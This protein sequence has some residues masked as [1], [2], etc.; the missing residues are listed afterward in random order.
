MIAKKVL[1]VGNFGVGKTSLIR[2]FVLNEF[3]EDYISTIGVRV[4][5]KIVE[6]N[7]EK[8]KLLIWDVAGTKDDEKVPKA[9]FLGAS[10]AMY[11]FDLSRE[12]TYLNIKSQINTVKELSGLEYITVVGNKKDLLT[13]TELEK[14]NKIISIPIDLVTSAKDDENVEDAFI[15]LAK[16]CLK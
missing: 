8:I 9:Y 6:L 7:S 4:S 15:A 13:S 3:S 12:E 10:A 16:Q 2:R 1:L 5:T 11:V 14:I